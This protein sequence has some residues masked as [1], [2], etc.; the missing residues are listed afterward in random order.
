MIAGVCVARAGV[1]IPPPHGVPK[2][3]RRCSAPQRSQLQA[4]GS[5]S[6]LLHSRQVCIP[7][8][9]CANSARAEVAQHSMQRR[10]TTLPRSTRSSA[11]SALLCFWY[12]APTQM[13]DTDKVPLPGATQRNAAR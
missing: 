11:I 8:R 9:F 12:H 5:D 6:V 10:L 1:A 4:A 3:L 13:L 7:H 2:P